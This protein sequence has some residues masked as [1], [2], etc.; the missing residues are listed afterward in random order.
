MWI[1]DTF[2]RISL[3]RFPR[4]EWLCKPS[5]EKHHE[6]TYQVHYQR[7]GIAVLRF[8]YSRCRYRAD[9]QGP[10]RNLEACLLNGSSRRYQGNEGWPRPKTDWAYDRNRNWFHYQL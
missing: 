10:R 6:P 9:G 7:S 1:D 5:M 4:C 2:N 3:R 8:C